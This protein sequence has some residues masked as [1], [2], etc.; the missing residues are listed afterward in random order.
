MQSRAENLL[1][2]CRYYLSDE[3][4]KRLMWMYIIYYECENNTTQ[5]A[6]KVGISREWLSKLKS[7]FERNGK[8]PRSLEPQSRAPHNTG[9]RERIDKNKENIIVK[10]RRQYPFLGKE[11]ISKIIERDYCIIISASTVGRYLS[12][13]HL[14]NPKLSE[15]NKKAWARK[16]EE[17][18]MKIKSRP[19]AKLK[20]YK[21]G[22]LLEKDIKFI[23]KADGFVNPLKYKAKENF[24]YQHTLCDSFTRIRVRD[25]TIDADSKTAVVAQKEMEKRLPFAIACINTDSGGENE[26]F[27]DRHLENNNIFHFYSRAG[28]PTDNPRVERSHLTDDLEFYSQGNIYKSFK[29]QKTAIIDNDYFYNHIRPHQAL[30]YLTPVEFYDLWKSN[31]NAAY[32]IVEKYRNYMNKQRKRLA[33]SR[34]IRRREQI[35][36]LM[37]FIDQKL[38]N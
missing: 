36:T 3:A 7:F 26:K 32:K 14:V 1:N 6:M 25:L 18:I 16:K 17:S 24:Y 28:M 31:P 35:E 38:T 21:P 37:Q 12:A 2:P 9:N 19:P 30:G 34:M 5:A 22:A 23:L 15:K 29:K 13:H 10:V 20:D 11:K 27:F 33:N 8:D 4:K